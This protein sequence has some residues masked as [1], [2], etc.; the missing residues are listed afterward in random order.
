[1]QLF[2]FAYILKPESA[3]SKGRSWRSLLVDQVHYGIADRVPMKKW[4]SRVIVFPHIRQPERNFIKIILNI[5]IVQIWNCWEIE[6]TETDFELVGQFELAMPVVVAIFPKIDFVNHALHWNRS[7]PKKFSFAT[8][9]TW[10]LRSFLAK[11]EVTWKEVS[12]QRTKFAGS[13]KSFTFLPRASG[14]LCFT[15]FLS[16]PFLLLHCSW[17]N[18]KTSQRHE[19]FQCWLCEG[20]WF[21]NTGQLSSESLNVQTSSSW[22]SCVWFPA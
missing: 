6:N 7:Y 3:G 13:L 8:V 21:T 15:I 19:L 17:N 18:S 11:R 10:H 12:Y 20:V 22:S 16:S 1:M 14:D 5:K 4:Q 9:I 2:E